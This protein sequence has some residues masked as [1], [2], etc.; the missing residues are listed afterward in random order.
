MN[1][2]LDSSVIAKLFIDEKGS[3]KATELLEKSSTKDIALIASNLA[4]YEVGNTILKHLREKDKDGTE[5][6]NQLFFLNIEYNSLDKTLAGEAIRIA[7]TNDI[8][9][10]D[11][12][13]IIVSQ[14]H[15]SALV[16]EDKELLKKFKNAISMKDALERI[17]K[18]PKPLITTI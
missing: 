1:L 8:T 4:F 3:D 16:T 2:V 7:K 12:V 11:A 6:M 10:Y 9:Y 18:E 13:H 5:Y 15:E 17:E 14:R